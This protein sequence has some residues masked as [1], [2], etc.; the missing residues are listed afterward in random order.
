MAMLQSNT[1]RIQAGREK[2]K[3]IQIRRSVPQGGPTSPTLF[4]LGID[5]IYKDT[6]ESDFANAHGFKLSDNHDALCLTGFADDQVAT[7]STIEGARRIVER[8]QELFR[9]IGLD[10]NPRKSIA[11]RIEKGK[12]VPGEL[13]LSDGVCIKCI[14]EN[15]VI[16][17]LGCS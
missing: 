4:N 10:V 13:E 2:S 14:D 17:Y 15:T 3:P 7:S 12:L 16:K 1:I 5:F 6:C 11:I 8:T 9:E